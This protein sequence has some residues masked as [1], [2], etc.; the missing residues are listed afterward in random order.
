[1]SELAHD[2]HIFEVLAGATAGTPVDVTPQTLVETQPRAFE[3]R[4][5]EVA[6]VVHD[7]RER[8]IVHESL[9][10][11]SQRASDSCRVRVDRRTRRSRLCGAELELAGVV[12]A[13][14]LVRV[15][16]L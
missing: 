5:I 1:M 8:C 12:E 15:A 6:A 10:G 16:V 2:K 4:R 9:G 13:E 14:Q 3:D 7:D 11:L